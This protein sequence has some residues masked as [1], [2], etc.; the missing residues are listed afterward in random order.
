MHSASA[1]GC[2]CTHTPLEIYQDPQSPGLGQG[3][4]SDEH[5]FSKL[6]RGLWDA[7]CPAGT[8]WVHPHPERRTFFSGHTEGR[9]WRDS[10]RT[11][12]PEAG[13]SPPWQ[14]LTCWWEC[15]SQKGCQ[16]SGPLGGGS[17][18][19][20]SRLARPEDSRTH[21]KPPLGRGRLGAICWAHSGE[22]TASPTQSPWGFPAEANCLEG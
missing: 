22:R 10:G 9:S 16:G 13:L 20:G 12:D 19:Q 17:Q 18:A 21:H 5:K 3:F 4:K 1:E 2:F 15:Q 11:E 8:L 6:Q 14:R 7:L